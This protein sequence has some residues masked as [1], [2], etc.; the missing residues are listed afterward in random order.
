MIVPVISLNL[1]YGQSF[2]YPVG[3][4]AMAMGHASV[5]TR[6]F[7][8]IFN[9]QAGAASAEHISA[10]AFFENRYLIPGMGHAAAG[11]MVP[12]GKGSI[13]LHIDHSGAQN[14]AETH[15]GTGY[16]MRLGNILSAGIQFD[17]FLMH[18]GEGY[19]NF[20][21]ITF[22]GG[23]M[24]DITPD[25][26]LGMHIFNPLRMKWLQTEEALPVNMR[27][28]LSYTGIMDLTLM[29]EVQKSTDNPVILC[30]GSGYNYREIFF[31]RA[32]VS[33]GPSRYTFGAGMRIKRIML[34]IS[35]GLHEWL[36]YSPQISITYSFEK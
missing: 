4:P 19:G 3:A 16:A 14:Y 22:E 1:S 9:N 15:S 36:G 34:D 11:L 6:D 8:S 20:H 35:S 28:G 21:A 27:G 5:A 17:H 29:A 10:G 32:G 26:I 12:A 23:I 33:T 31:F 30:I 13:F 18:I 24:A 2:L 25:L 7:W